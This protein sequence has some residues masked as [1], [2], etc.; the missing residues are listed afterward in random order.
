MAEDKPSTVEERSPK[1][2]GND[3]MVMDLIVR[4]ANLADGRL[5]VDIGV[6]D[7]RIAA[8]EPQLKV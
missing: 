8:V 1:N 3:D 6:K 7:G 5:G 4:S 2:M